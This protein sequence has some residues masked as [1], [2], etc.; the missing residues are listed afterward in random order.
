MYHGNPFRQ[1]MPATRVQAHEKHLAGSAGIYLSS[2]LE[3][4]AVFCACY[5]SN[6]IVIAWSTKTRPSG[7]Q[8]SR[9]R[10]QT[11]IEMIC[12]VS[13]G[14]SVRRVAHVDRTRVSLR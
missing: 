13:S 9:S 14:T 2:I 10:A 6:R 3:H 5:G 11:T 1:T 7:S 8:H 4:I 12:G